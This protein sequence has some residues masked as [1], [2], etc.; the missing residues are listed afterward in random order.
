[1]SKKEKEKLIVP[2][3]IR[4]TTFSGWVPEIKSYEYRLLA[5]EEGLKYSR[6]RFLDIN[7]CIIGLHAPIKLQSVYDKAAL[8]VKQNTI[9]AVNEL[10][11]AVD[12]VAGIAAETVAEIKQDMSRTAKHTAGIAFNILG[13]LH[14]FVK[15]RVSKDEKEEEQTASTTTT[16]TKLLN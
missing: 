14:S 12:E 11:H 5:S 4:T 1:M 16:E 7:G 15:D 2:V 10:K 3:E 6:I 13:N 9:K 8:Q